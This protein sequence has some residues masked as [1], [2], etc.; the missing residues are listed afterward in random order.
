MLPLDNSP[1]ALDRCFEPITEIG[2]RVAVIEIQLD[3]GDRHMHTS[4]AASPTLRHDDTI[5]LARFP[6]RDSVADW[7]IAI[8]ALLLAALLLLI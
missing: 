6:A 3:S 4:A 5:Q 8:G 7:P 2:T 1:A